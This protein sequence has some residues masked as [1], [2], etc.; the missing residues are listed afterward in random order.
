M[1]NNAIKF[2]DIMNE[3]TVAYDKAEVLI[4][5]LM[6]EP[7][8]VDVVEAVSATDSK[9]TILEPLM[10]LERAKQLMDRINDLRL[11]SYVQKNDPFLSR[12]DYSG[13]RWFDTVMEDA[14]FRVSVRAVRAIRECFPSPQVDIKDAKQIS[15][16]VSTGVIKPAQPFNPKREEGSKKLVYCSRNAMI[17]PASEVY[18]GRDDTAGINVLV[19]EVF[20]H[21]EWV[22]SKTSM[23]VEIRG[24]DV[25]TN[26]SIYRVIDG[27]LTKSTKVVSLVDAVTEQLADLYEL[28]FKNKAHLD[29]PSNERFLELVH[30]HPEVMAIVGD[31]KF[32]NMMSDLVK[33]DNNHTTDYE[34]RIAYRQPVRRALNIIKAAGGKVNVDLS[35]GRS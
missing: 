19:H 11:V 25:E 17:T 33:L 23:I 3:L 14:H 35:T 10:V 31:D 5:A 26:N 13:N 20:V 22:T 29:L 34:L 2:I 15:M 21:D 16:L 9:V 4:H 18:P 27:S 1:N 8:L 24:S 28:T 32:N 7:D 30:A 6:N 12:T